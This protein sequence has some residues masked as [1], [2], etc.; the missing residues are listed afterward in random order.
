MRPNQRANYRISS[1][2][3]LLSAASLFYSG[4]AFVVSMGERST[5]VIGAWRRQGVYQGDST[6]GACINNAP[7]KRDRGFAK[8]LLMT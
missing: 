7:L 8:S 6:S 3:W 5:A 1:P 4:K 2:L